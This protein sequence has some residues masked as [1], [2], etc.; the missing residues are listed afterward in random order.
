M[1]TLFWEYMAG[2]IVAQAMLEELGANYKLRYVDMGA[3]EHKTP[4]YLS[5][6]PS[7]RVPAIGFSDGTTIGETSAIVTILGEQFPKSQL[8]PQPGDPKRTSFLFWLNVMATSGY[9]TVARHGHPERYASTAD[10]IS[11]VELKA[12]AD[13]NQFFDLMNNV[14]S[15]SPYFL[16]I[17]YSALD[18][19]LTML[20]EWSQ[21]KELL[22]ST[23]PALAALASATV[24]RSAYQTAMDTHLLVKRD[25]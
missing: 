21:D 9:L 20:T 24:E 11:Q 4:A 1:Y 18:I 22:F 3:D 23:R 12:S 8:T 5:L 14:I 6:V 13:L 25:I 7:G 16:P 10:A 19:Y 17:G 2:S 15:G